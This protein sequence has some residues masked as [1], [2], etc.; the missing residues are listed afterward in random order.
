MARIAATAALAAL[1]L[2][3]AC[4]AFGMAPVLGGVGPNLRQVGHKKPATQGE[5][6]RRVRMSSVES[7]TTAATVS[8]TPGWRDGEFWTWRGMQV[9]YAALNPHAQG[10][11]LLLV[12]GEGNPRARSPPPLLFGPTPQACGM[13]ITNSYSYQLLVMTRGYRFRCE[14][15]TLARQRRFF[16]AGQAR[17]RH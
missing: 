17:L 11:P 15:G 16:V 12:H 10:T 6:R 4:S 2:L 13:L 7:G 1:V 3:P 5:N 14:P 8:E 9:R